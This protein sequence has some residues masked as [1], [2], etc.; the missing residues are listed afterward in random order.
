MIT[1]IRCIKNLRIRTQQAENRRR[2]SLDNR[3]QR[4]EQDR[5][6][7]SEIRRERDDSIGPL[8]GESEPAPEPF[9]GTA[10]IEKQKE[11]QPEQCWG[12]HQAVHRRNPAPT[13]DVMTMMTTAMT[14]M[15]TD[16]TAELPINIVKQVTVLKP[17]AGDE[18]RAKTT[19]VAELG[20]RTVQ[21]ILQ[22]NTGETIKSKAPTRRGNRWR[23]THQQPRHTRYNQQQSYH[24]QQ[25]YNQPY[26]SINEFGHG[27]Y[28]QG[29]CVEQPRW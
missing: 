9:T 24:A 27:Q 7:R 4:W 25:Y 20:S 18:T 29:Y 14:I 3:N 10:G 6:D 8:P 23:T 17:V 5:D 12:D 22:P 19:T 16:I 28:Q 2:E 21:I 11:M 26:Y 13:G 15:T 1:T